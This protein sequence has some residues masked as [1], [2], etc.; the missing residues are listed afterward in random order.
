MAELQRRNPQ[1]PQQ[2]GLPNGVAPRLPTGSAMAANGTPTSS[3]NLTVP[4][5]NRPRPMPPQMPGQQMPNGVRVPPMSMNGVPPQT[6]QGQLPLPNPALDI[7][8][9]TR[10]QK[11]S[12]QQQQLRLQQQGHSQSPQ[13]HNSPP[14]MNGLPQP[15]FPMQN[16]MMPPFNS[17]I[18]GVGTPPAHTNSP[19]QGQAGS[20]RMGQNLMNGV[21][22]ISSLEQHYKQQ[23]PTATSDQITTLIRNHL[24]KNVNQQQQ[25]QRQ[26][27]AQ[28]AMN[29][30]AGSPQTALAAMNALGGGQNPTPQMYAAMLRQQ[31]ET[32]Q[33]NAQQ[34]QHQAANS[35]GNGTAQNMVSGNT[36]QGH[37][38]RASS[39]SVNSGK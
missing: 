23:Y 26:G 39:G 31:Q 37:A 34:L 6:M 4:G 18:N 16:N 30:A 36:G 1:N 38:H 2:A 33:K 35:V 20:P 29:A 8:L 13:M 12:Q 17:N 22:N 32:Q 9:V 7:G 3:Q 10:A 19:S 5:Q 14:R 21:P 27:L 28:S 11:I 15:G 24:A 25:Q